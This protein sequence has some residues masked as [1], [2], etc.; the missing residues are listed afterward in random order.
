MTEQKL[1]VH[2]AKLALIRDDLSGCL[3]ALRALRDEVVKLKT[4]WV[5]PSATLEAAVRGLQQAVSMTTA[6]IP[7]VQ[8]ADLEDETGT[9]YPGR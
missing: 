7:L 8:H 1:S 4:D 3:A 9:G 6:A 5:L 2:A